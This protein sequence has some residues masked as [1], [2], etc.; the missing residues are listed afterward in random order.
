MGNQN[1][2]QAE[3]VVVGGGAA[4]SA[5]AYKLA[6]AGKRVLLMEKGKSL[7]ES[8]FSRISGFMGC[9]TSFQKA[10]G[11]TVASKKNLYE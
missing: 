7:L 11:I 5:A 1:I 4:G 3:C 9:E 8:D 10:A 2:F 6:K